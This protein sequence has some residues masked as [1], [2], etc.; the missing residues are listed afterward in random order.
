MNS[1]LVVMF[2]GSKAKINSVV[3]RR[4]SAELQGH[5]HTTTAG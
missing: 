1:D 3:G 2:P 4:R 5:M